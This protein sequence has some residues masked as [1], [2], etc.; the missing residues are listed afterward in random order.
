MNGFSWWAIKH[1]EDQGEAFL[2]AVAEQSR[3]RMALKVPRAQAQM[4]AFLTDRILAISLFSDPQ[5]S[6]LLDINNN[7]KYP[8]YPGKVFLSKCTWNP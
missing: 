2:V 3:N 1:G 5:L 7:G 6:N 8:D 4:P